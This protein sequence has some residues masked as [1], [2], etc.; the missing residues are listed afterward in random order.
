[1]T[2]EVIFVGIKIWLKRSF[3]IYGNVPTVYILANRK[4]GALYTGVTSNLIQRVGQH[5]SHFIDGFTRKYNVDKLV[6]FEV[7]E[8]MLSAIE[9]EKQIK[10]WK[11]AW[12]IEMI[13]AENPDWFD[14][15]P[16]ISN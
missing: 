1:M 7:H 11:R 5:K 16:E 4:H 15:N 14:L 6:W 8:T 10:K 13:E 2:A 9:R 12:K 3:S